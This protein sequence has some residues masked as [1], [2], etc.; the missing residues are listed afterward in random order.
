VDEP[1]LLAARSVS[2][3]YGANRVLDDISLE[4][5][6]GVFSGV[7]GP[8]GSGKTT[9]LRLLVG[10]LETTRGEVLFRGRPLG[11]VDERE[12]ARA[13]AWV[14]Q[15]VGVDFPFTVVE[16]VLF[17]RTP[18][19]GGWGLP[20]AGDLEIARDAMERCDVLHLARRSAL[21]L[22]GGERRRVLLARALAQRPRL[23]L[24]DEPAAFLDIRHQ[25]EICDLL[26]EGCRRGEFGVVAVL[27]D[28]NLAA[29]YCG[30]LL[31]LK[32]GRAAAQGAVE[33]VL[34]YGHVRE[35][36]GAEV[37]VGVNEI[38]GTR[39]LIPMGR[40]RRNNR[41]GTPCDA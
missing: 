33:E 31:L 2:F 26:A 11:E 18:H 3:S 5:Q 24:L 28:L 8:N 32:D 39:F 41:G 15:D 27:H 14:P 37:Y 38:A 6:V 35:A 10:S 16:L 20:N 21:E 12:R 40:W 29:A 4:G 9:L 7:L 34:T 22:S 30:H 19:R 23:L 1:A 36:F 25:V 17:G 13:V